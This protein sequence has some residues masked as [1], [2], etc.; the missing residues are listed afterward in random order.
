MNELPIVEPFVKVLVLGLFV[1]LVLMLRRCGF[2]GL[3]P[4]LVIRRFEINADTTPAVLIEGR[5]SGFFA[6]IATAIGLD[7]VTLLMV[8]NEQ[9]R[10]KRTSVCGEIHD[11]IPTTAVSSTQ[12]GYNQPIGLLIFA[13]IN[14]VL[15][16]LLA[17]Y[18]HSMAVILGGL[19]LGLICTLLY[20]FQ[21]QIVIS[22][23]TAGGSRI[24]IAFKSS[25]IEGVHVN[26]QK[27][28]QVIARING[29]VIARS[30]TLA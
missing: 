17:L 5:P 3:G 25:A 19:A 13:A 23:E 22:V 20:V 11:V 26:L 8:T 6:W 14:L 10:L 15:A 4:T 29:I 9:I 16:F 1:A 12:C 2:G 28:L 27:A 18:A 7:T 24:G 21:R 30:A